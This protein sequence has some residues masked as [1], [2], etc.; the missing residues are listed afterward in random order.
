MHL[1]LLVLILF[2]F[3]VPGGKNDHYQGFS[4]PDGNWRV[5]P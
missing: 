5:A 3:V 4:L 2:G 1:L